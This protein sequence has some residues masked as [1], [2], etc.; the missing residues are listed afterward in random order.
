VQ[1]VR[2]P[3]GSEGPEDLPVDRGHVGR[4]QR[5]GCAELIERFRIAG[6]SRRLGFRER[7]RSGGVAMEA[8]GEVWR[9]LPQGD[10][11]PGDA[12]QVVVD[13]GGAAPERD[14]QPR[15]H[16]QPALGRRVRRIRRDCRLHQAR[17]VLVIEVIG[18]LVRAGAQARGFLARGGGE[19]DGEQ[20]Q[21]RG[22][23]TSTH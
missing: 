12:A 10:V 8:G 17:C 14:E 7:Q 2:A 22:G 15:D 9:R 4:L 6:P 3:G 1:V 11:L 18:E 20:E 13:R 23:G 21:R 16:R 19:R 5:H